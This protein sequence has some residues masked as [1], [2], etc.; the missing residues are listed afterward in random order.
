MFSNISSSNSK[1]EIASN[2]SNESRASLAAWEARL[3][4]R[5]QQQNLREQKQEAMANTLGGL[6]DTLI[7]QAEAFKKLL[8][9]RIAEDTLPLGCTCREL[10]PEFPRGGI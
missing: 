2:P 10:T 9:E 6:R 5:E 7:Q 8:D 3:N 4:A 1:E